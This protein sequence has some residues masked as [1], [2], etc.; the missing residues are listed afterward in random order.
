MICGFLPASWT[1]KMTTEE[2]I[3][4]VY[5]RFGLA[6]YYGQVLEHGIVNALLVLQISKKEIS[7]ASDIEIFVDQ[8][9]ENTLGRLIKNLKSELTLPP[10]LEERLREALKV[11]NYLCHNFFR[12]RVVECNS[13][14]GRDKLLSELSDAREL[15]EAADE[16]LTA[17]VE[18][19]SESCGLTQERIN[20]AFEKLKAQFKEAS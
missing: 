16:M 11:R 2:Q 4:E 18:P 8:Q 6:V 10:G 14:T 20:E 1:W 17:V 9:F 7:C 5:A 3:R 19:Y 13:T 15:L 12:E